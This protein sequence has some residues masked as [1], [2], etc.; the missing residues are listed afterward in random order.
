MDD[1]IDRRG[2]RFLFFARTFS[3]ENFEKSQYVY[4]LKTNRTNLQK[5]DFFFLSLLKLHCVSE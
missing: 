3:D 1:L 5:F 2:Y 4:R